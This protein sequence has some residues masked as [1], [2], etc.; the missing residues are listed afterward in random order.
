MSLEINVKEKRY[1]GKLI[2]DN[3]KYSFQETGIYALTAES[4]KGKTTLL[5]IIS[6]L[7]SDFQGTVIGGGFK[8]V[9]VHFQEYR[10]FP[11]LTAKENVIMAAKVTEEDARKLLSFLDFKDEDMNLFPDE[12]SGGM[13][14]R[15]SLAR[16]ILK[17]SS[18]LLLDEP[19]KELDTELKE[20]L[21]KVLIEE[22]KK[23]LIIFSTHE[24]RDVMALGA[25][26][27]EI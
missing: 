26:V 27:V 11:N 15:V 9:S 18:V 13:K 24:N 8:N 14:Q 16:A 19:T 21:Y 22:G 10:L 2:F 25:S 3:F 23:R 7:D 12:L 1:G 4:G 20:K 17:K 5:R 6:E